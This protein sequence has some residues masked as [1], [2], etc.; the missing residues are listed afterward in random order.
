MHILLTPKQVA[1]ALG[2]SVRS[3]ERMRSDGTGPQFIRASGG[4]RRG[5]VVYAERD[6]TEWL[7]ARR[8]TSTSDHGHGL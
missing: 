6:L 7:N 8:R 3:L 2:V 1:A 5:R 4:N